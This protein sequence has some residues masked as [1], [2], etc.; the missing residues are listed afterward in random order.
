MKSVMNH[1]FQNVPDV[2]LPRAQFDLS[3][4][5]KLTLDG[6]YIVPLAVFEVL[7]GD[8]WNTYMN[9]FGRMTTPLVPVM[10]N[11]YCDTF[12]FYSPMRLLWENW[13]KFCGEQVDP[14]DSTDYT[15]PVMDVTTSDL[16]ATGFVNG[17]LADYFGLPTEVVALDG[18]SALPFRMYN[19]I[20]N[21]WFRDENLQDSVT[22][23]MG[24]ADSD[25]GDYVLL[26]RAKKRDY[27]SGCLPW[28][29]KNNT[30]NA[31]T[32]PLGT[33][34]PIIF[35]NFAGGATED[36]KY[37]MYLGDGDS[38][39]DMYFGSTWN[40]AAGATVI[41]ANSDA[42]LIADLSTATA[43]TI[44]ELREAFATQRLYERDAR[45]GTRYIELLRSHFG[46]SSSDRSLQRTEYLAGGSTPIN[47]NTVANT[48]PIKAADAPQG[49]DVNQGD[50]TGFGTYAGNL[51][52]IKSFEEHG[53][54]MLLAN[55]RAD[56]TYQE[57]LDRMWSRST[58]LDFY[59][60]SLAHLG[61]QPVYKKEL[62]C[63][64]TATDDAVFGYQERYADYKYQ[65]S[66]IMGKYRSNYASAIDQWHLSEEFGAHQ[67]LNAAFIQS[68]TPWDRC[69]AVSTEHDFK[70][71]VYITNK[72]VRCMPLF[73]D[74]GYIDHF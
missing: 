33:E 5:R 70:M 38:N 32:L 21:E 14:A 25:D 26:K 54:I 68:N 60:P 39:P 47:I 4:G 8:S 43:S 67:T 56:I 55:F 27:I 10:D 73:S 46:V 17:K 41:A 9:F 6:D 37:L 36:G 66:K 71:D 40:S 50:L 51:N 57:S 49:S 30:G 20:Y 65:P 19:R 1:N 2:K 72:V 35:D 59:W 12:A 64:A 45:G 11:I 42:N 22:V 58:R 3:C 34:A 23:D 44:N 18:I 52:F 15:I 24:D 53:Y 61:E 28:V 29:S 62:F 7:P 69:L 48:S 16:A 31:V 63:D 13:K 74:P